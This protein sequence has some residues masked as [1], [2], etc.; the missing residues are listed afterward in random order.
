M[1]ESSAYSGDSSRSPLAES[2]SPRLIAHHHHHH[3]HHHLSSKTPPSTTSEHLFEHQLD[4][5]RNLYSPESRRRTPASGSASLFTIDSILAPRSNNNNNDSSSPNHNNN[6]SSSHNNNNN[7]NN[8]STAALVAAASLQ[9]AIHDRSAEVSSAVGTNGSV[10]QAAAAAAAA[11][12][13]VGVHP[14][15]QQ[16]HH[17]AFTSADFL[18]VMTKRKR[19]HRTIFTEEQLEQLENT[20]EQTHYPDV[21]LRER[22]A[23]QVDLKEERI[24]VW[25]KNRRAKWRKQKREEQDRVRK[26]QMD[27]PRA[28]NATSGET[29]N[30]NPLRLAA[31]SGGPLQSRHHDNDSSSDLEVA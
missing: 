10:R 27:R 31:Q 9:S 30:V 16:L 6:S 13:A 1:V 7:N 19:R 23:M 17:L 15:Q 28:N 5:Q 29:T 8:I 22:L 11:A 14:L 25:F 21:L 20:F 26:L 2:P 24:E 18:G 3:H 4:L 12:A